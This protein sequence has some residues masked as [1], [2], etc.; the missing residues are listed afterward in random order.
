MKAESDEPIEL[1][2]DE[3]RELWEAME[4]IRRSEYVDGEDL[5]N[6]LHSLRTREIKQG[7]PVLSD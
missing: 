2:P 6:E 7:G 3:E 1:S 5:L 4:E